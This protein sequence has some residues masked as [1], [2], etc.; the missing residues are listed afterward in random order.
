VLESYHYERKDILKRA[1]A[2]GRELSPDEEKRLVKLYSER[3]ESYLDA[4]HGGCWLR[5]PN[6]GGIVAGALSHFDGERYHLHAWMVMP[7]HVHAVLTPLEGHSL[8]R[9]LHS[10]KSFTA[11]EAQNMAQTPSL[12]IPKGE[13]FWQRESYDHLVRDEAEFARVCEYTIQNPVYAGLCK[14]PEDWPFSSAVVFAL[15]TAG[16]PPASIKL[17]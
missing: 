8:S 6:I 3:I 9:I 14:R 17:K 1:E 10:W 12:Q 4:G 15:R 13:G 16:V 11:H 5:D 7:N 2:Q